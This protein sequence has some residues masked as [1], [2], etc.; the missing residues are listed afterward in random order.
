[1][2]PH[3]VVRTVELTG[4]AGI[5][6]VFVSV[7]LVPCLLD[8]VK[9]MLPGDVPRLE[10]TEGY[11][12]RAPRGPSLKTLVRRAIKTDAADE[13]ARRLV[14]RDPGRRQSVRVCLVASA[15]AGCAIAPPA[16]PRISAS[17]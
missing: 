6:A 5:R 16:A 13:F 15:C 12:A 17:D 9:Y 8:G 10:G 1:M 3:M 11:R 2:I 14:K 4:Y 7:P